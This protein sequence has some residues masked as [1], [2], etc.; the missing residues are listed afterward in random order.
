MTN[1]YRRLIDLLPEND[2]REV[3]KVVGT[4]TTHTLLQTRAGGSIKVLGTGVA[5]GLMA[6]FK[7]GR[8]EGAAPNLPTYDIE[9]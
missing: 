5:V 8:L 2:Q 7:G 4:T 6:Y 3:G 1:V 9:V